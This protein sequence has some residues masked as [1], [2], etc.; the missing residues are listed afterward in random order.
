MIQS[1][2]FISV[3]KESKVLNGKSLMCLAREIEQGLTL[4]I[5]LD[6]SDSTITGMGFDA[7]AKGLSL[8]EITYKILLLWKRRTNRFKATQVDSLISALQE[9]GRDDVAVVV[10][11]CHKNNKELTQASFEFSQYNNP[12]NHGV[13]INNMVL[14]N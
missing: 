3:Q 6:I 11:E 4:A 2:I 1:L 10:R 13:F 12:N 9:M 14:N 8:V 5:H 7:L